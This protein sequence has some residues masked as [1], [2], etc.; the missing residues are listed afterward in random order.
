MQNVCGEIRR[1]LVFWLT[2]RLCRARL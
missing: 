1:R 2:I